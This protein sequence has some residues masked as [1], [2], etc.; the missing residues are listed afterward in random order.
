MAEIKQTERAARVLKD[1]MDCCK[2]YRH[3]FVMPEHLLLVLADEFCFDRTLTEH[4]ISFI[5]SKGL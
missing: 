1:T 2:D 4:S 5:R 3:E